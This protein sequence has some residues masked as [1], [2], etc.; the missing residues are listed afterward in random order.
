M[1]KM[2][3]MIAVIAVLGAGAALAQETAPVTPAN[4][5][6]LASRSGHWSL[7]GGLGMTLDPD[8]FAGHAGVDYY[9]TNEVAVGPL[10]QGGVGGP[11][12]YWGLSGQVKYS[13]ALATAQIVRPYGTVGIGF[14][15]FDLDEINHGERKISFLFPIG[16]GMEFEVADDVSLDV[17]ALFDISEDVFIGLFFGGRYLF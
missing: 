5:G 4:P 15:Q 11:G 8:L 12:G 16:G 17:G 3:A 9:L 14:I 2:A 1:R 10:F 7:G 13:A 6:S